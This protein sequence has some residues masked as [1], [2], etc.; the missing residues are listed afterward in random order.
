MRMKCKSVQA[1]TM[2]ECI[3]HDLT[4]G[5]RVFITIEITM[6]MTTAGTERPRTF[7]NS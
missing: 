6:V 5:Q 4:T 7:Y 3:N 2:I 1:D